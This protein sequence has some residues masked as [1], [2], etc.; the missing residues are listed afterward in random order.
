MSL[1]DTIEPMHEIKVFIE[2]AVVIGS[3]KGS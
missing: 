2:S 1:I 3:V